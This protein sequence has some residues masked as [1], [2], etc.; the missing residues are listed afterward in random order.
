[1]LRG[2]S[3]SLFLL[4]LSGVGKTVALERAKQETLARLSEQRKQVNFVNLHGVLH[5]DEQFA[6]V[7]ILRQL[8]ETDSKRIRV[9]NS[10]TSHAMSKK[11]FF[12]F[13]CARCRLH[14]L[15]FH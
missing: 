6:T 10:I 15:H 5:S 4:G 8:G 11:R 13:R 2:E 3:S 12:V 1:V 14:A 7:E 9:S